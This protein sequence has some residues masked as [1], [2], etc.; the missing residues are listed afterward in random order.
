MGQVLGGDQRFQGADLTALDAIPGASEILIA[1]IADIAGDRPIILTGDFNTN[2][3]ERFRTSVDS[4]EVFLRLTQDAYE[5]DAYGYITGDVASQFAPDFGLVDSYAESLGGL[6]ALFAAGDIH[7]TF[8]GDPDL[9]R[10][11]PV[12]IDITGARVDYIFA[13][14]FFTVEAAEILRSSYLIAQGIFDTTPDFWKYSSDHYAI[15]T[16]FSYGVDDT[17]PSDPTDPD[18]PSVVPLPAGSLLLLSGL[19]MLALRRRNKNSSPAVR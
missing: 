17:L 14:E 15:S 2:V 10:D 12:D 9:K 3:T 1:E 13:S 11:L 4:T 7:T 5:L 8:S 19:G 18:D 16:L 6:E